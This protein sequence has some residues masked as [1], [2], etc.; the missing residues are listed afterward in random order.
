MNAQQSDPVAVQPFR[1]DIPEVDLDDLKQRLAHTR[2]TEELPGVEWEYGVPLKYVQRLADHWRHAYDWRSWE[3]KLNAHPQFLT[4]L[5]GQRIHFLHVRSPEPDAFP[6]LLTHGWPGSVIEFM[7]VIGPLSDP[8]AHGAPEAPAFHL[9]IPSLPGFAFSGPTTEQGWGTV[10]T[11]SAWAELMRRLGYE[12]YGLHGND[13]GSM[14]SPHV[15]RIDAERVAGVHVTQVFSFPSGDPAE[16]EGMSPEDLAGLRHLQEFWEKSGAFNKLQSTQ[17]QTLA[18]ALADSPVGQLAWNAQLFGE[19]AVSDDFIITNVMLYWLTN[20]AA[21]SA[22]FYYESAHEDDTAE[23]TTVPLGHAGFAGDFVSIRRFA[24]RD[25]GNI[26]H[27]KTYE[28]G[29]HYSA[30]QASQTLCED[31]RAFF[32]PLV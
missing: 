14:V 20:T 8:R 5:D 24:E 16:M 11:A 15:G 29:G 10:R 31:I 13:I 23:P 28:F 25:H 21:S 2:F 19:R 22:R 4:E 17:P 6:L 32:D 12:R 7:D 18:H 26:V 27:W 9:V 1:V 3:R 30:H